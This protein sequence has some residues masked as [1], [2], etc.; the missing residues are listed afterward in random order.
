MDKLWPI[1]ANPEAIA[2]NQAWAGHS[3]SPFK[4]ADHNITWWMGIGGSPHNV[5]VPLWQ[6]FQKPVGDGKVAILLVNH[7]DV[8]RPME[9]DLHEVPGL[10]CSNCE[11]RDVWARQD[12][13][14]MMKLDV[15]VGSHDTVFFLLSPAGE[16][17]RSSAGELE[18][19]L[20]V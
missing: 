10:S 14:R 3:G 16:G 11:V 15:T 20:L 6:Y 1:I 18:D 5:S 12:L 17:A 7:D 13:G 4:E 8:S 9:L 2:I 19:E